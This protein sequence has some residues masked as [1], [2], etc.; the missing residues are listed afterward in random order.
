M[1][2]KGDNK[3]NNTDSE[4]T[5]PQNH[6]IKNKQLPPKTVTRISWS[7]VSGWFVGLLIFGFLWMVYLLIRAVHLA[8]KANPEIKKA[9][10]VLVFVCLVIFLIK[11]KDR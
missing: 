3:I 9:I 5:A 8:L 1:E 2:N 11:A 6:D 10:L 4:G 7:K